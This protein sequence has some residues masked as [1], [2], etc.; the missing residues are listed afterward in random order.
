MATTRFT[1]IP[2]ILFLVLAL[3]VSAQA[4]PS[5]PTGDGGPSRQQGGVVLY[6][7]NPVLTVGDEDDWDAGYVS[8]G[9][10]LVHDGQYHMF[11]GGST[12]AYTDPISIGHATSPDGFEWT[13]DEANPVLVPGQVNYP[14][15]YATI[16]PSSALVEG[17]TWMLFFSLLPQP[18]NWFKSVLYRATATD[19]SGP[20]T[21]DP[22][23]LLDTGPSRRWDSNFLLWPK[24]VPTDEGYRMY[25]LGGFVRGVRLGMATSTDGVTWTKYDDPATDERAFDD[26][27]PLLH[28]QSTG[29]WNRD[30]ISIY[31]IWQAGDGWHIFHLAGYWEIVG[32]ISHAYATSP[33][34][35]AWEWYPVTPLWTEDLP[36]SMSWGIEGNFA[37]VPSEEDDLIRVYGDFGFDTYADQILLGFWSPPAVQ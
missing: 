8:M 20:W 26:S 24:V 22:A 4:A 36:D 16:L 30:F 15:P 37:V 1:A 28:T 18:G 23:P 33:D 29:G 32:E 6:D 14:S 19:P 11:Y 27:D 10:I 17:D 3:A 2:F 5:A 7:G 25:Y 12:M 13:K 31:D 35:I 34:G 21:V 9:D